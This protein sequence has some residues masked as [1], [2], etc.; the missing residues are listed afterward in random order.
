MNFVLIL[1]MR[2]VL[3]LYSNSKHII[4]LASSYGVILEY[5]LGTEDTEV[6]NILHIRYK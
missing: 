1:F 2:L 3:K 6:D 4:Q 5:I